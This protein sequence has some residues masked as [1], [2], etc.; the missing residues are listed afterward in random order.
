M[1][2]KRYWEK[3]KFWK[4]AGERI[5]TSFLFTAIALMTTSGDFNW[6]VALTGGVA[7]LL[8]TLKAWVGS[9]IKNSTT[10]A[11]II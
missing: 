8:S 2:T 9:Q 6:K 4:D 10:P 5:V 11:S 1:S 3:P 7:A